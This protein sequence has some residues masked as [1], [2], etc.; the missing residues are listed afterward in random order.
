[1]EHI[2]PVRESELLVVPIRVYPLILCFPWFQSM[3]PDVDWQRNR[4]LALGTPGVGE[5]VAVD[6][7]N[8]QECSGNVHESTTREEACSVEGGGLPDSVPNRPG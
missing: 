5:D 7:V 2:A 8:L 6:W 4:L 3:S 1:M